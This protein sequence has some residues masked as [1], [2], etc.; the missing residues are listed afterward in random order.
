MDSRAS[1]D[2]IVLILR[3]IMLKNKNN[4]TILIIIFLFTSTNFLKSPTTRGSNLS[5]RYLIPNVNKYIKFFL[6]C[7]AMLHG[8]AFV[9]NIRE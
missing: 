5:V 2:E 4:F 8:T 6:L 1:S 3:E 9:A 7:Y